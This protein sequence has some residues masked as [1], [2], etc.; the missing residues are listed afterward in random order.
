VY[1]NPKRSNPQ[2]S[3]SVLIPLYREKF[4]SI[5]TTVKSIA[6]QIYPKGLIEVVLI[7]ESDDHQTKSSVAKVVEF[8]QKNGIRSIVVESNSTPKMKA[9]ALNQALKVVNSDVIAVY[10]ADDVFPK[11]QFIKA[12]ALIEMGYDVVGVKVPRYRETGVGKYLF[13]DTAV[14]YT[15]I[16]PVFYKLFKYVPLSGEG[17]FIKRT[18]LE[19]IGGFPEVLA[20]D[21]CL[22]IML[23]EKGLKIAL[24]DSWVRELA[25]K[26]L[27]STIKQRLR[28][29]KGYLQ[30]LGVLMKS[31]IPGKVKAALFVMYLSPAVSGTAF[32][33]SF[34]TASYTTFKFVI[35]PSASYMFDQSLH[36]IILLAM[37]VVSLPIIYTATQLTPG[38]DRRESLVLHIVTLP[39]YWTLLGFVILAS[40]FIPVRSWMKTERR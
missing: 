13:I 14:W 4:D 3:I 6:R 32:L 35:D 31:K 36:T 2:L 19:K 24:L 28:W 30:C 39:L 25:P 11:D 5:M 20:E 7:V 17:L 22:T 29:S 18:V 33:V 34:Y 15:L 37:Y 9:R 8:L 12:V 16:I 27:A 40:P 26:N 10:D 21:A 1:L 23:A 38:N